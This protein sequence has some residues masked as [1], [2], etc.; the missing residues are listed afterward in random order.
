MIH[1]MNPNYSEFK[2]PAIKAHAWNKVFR[3]RTPQDAI[4]LI[5]RLLVY[6]PER[7]LTPLEALQHAFFD[8]LRCQEQKLPNGSP[9]PPLFDFTPE[10]RKI[11]TQ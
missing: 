10:E 8:D 4:D 5:N 1:T 2:F 3:A 9:L 6:N 7:R 11:M